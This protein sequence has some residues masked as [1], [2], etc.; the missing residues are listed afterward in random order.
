MHNADRFVPPSNKA[1]PSLH[2]VESSTSRAI[3]P[4]LQMDSDSQTEFANRAELMEH[5]AERWDGMS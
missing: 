4:P 5:E 1:N 2:R 3:Q